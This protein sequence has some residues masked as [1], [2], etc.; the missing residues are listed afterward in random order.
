MYTNDPDLVDT[1]QPIQQDCPP[2]LLE[3]PN[4]YAYHAY[5]IYSYRKPSS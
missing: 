1:R 2:S 5:R 4:K 3:E